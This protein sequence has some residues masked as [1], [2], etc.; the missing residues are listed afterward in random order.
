MIE[1]KYFTVFFFS[2]RI[3]IIML[4]VFSGICLIYL[5]ETCLCYI[6][7]FRMI[8]CLQ[9]RNAYSFYNFTMKNST[10]LLVFSTFITCVRKET[11]NCFVWES[12]RLFF[13]L[14]LNQHSLSL[15]RTFTDTSQNF[16]SKNKKS[17]VQS[18][19]FKRWRSKIFLLYFPL[20]QIFCRTLF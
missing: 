17:K 6:C 20:G 7:F 1:E 14:I 11:Y 5:M 15:S 13:Q 12:C 19:K 16:I 18:M 8:F 2:L 3:L 9:K 10:F 4:K